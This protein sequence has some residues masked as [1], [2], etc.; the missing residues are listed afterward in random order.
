MDPHQTQHL[1]QLPDDIATYFC[2]TMR[3]MP[4]AAIDPSLALGFYCR[5]VCVCGLPHW[6]AAMACSVAPGTGTRRRVNC[7][8]ANAMYKTHRPP[9]LLLLLLL[10]LLLRGQQEKHEQALML[11]PVLPLTPHPTCSP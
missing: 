2:D 10:L 8:D 6:H 3:L 5:Y 9:P 7:A 4:L 11:L 1:A